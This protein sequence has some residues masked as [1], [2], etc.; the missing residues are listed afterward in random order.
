MKETG[1]LSQIAH[2]IADALQALG[3]IAIGT[4]KFITHHDAILAVAAVYGALAAKKLFAGL[5]TDLVTFATAASKAATA[6]KELKEAQTVGDIV[7]TVVGKVVLK[8]RLPLKQ[9][10][11]QHN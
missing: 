6:L 7:D 8:R 5:A 1:E 10:H 3:K 9:Q 4:A 11:G 2:D